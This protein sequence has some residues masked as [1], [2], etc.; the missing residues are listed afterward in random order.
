MKTTPTRALEVIANYTPMD[1]KVKELAMKTALRVHTWGY[2]TNTGRGHS[3]IRK[4]TGNVNIMNMYLMPKD[5]IITEYI[6]EKK[7]TT[8]IGS[9]EEWKTVKIHDNYDIVCKE[10]NIEGYSSL[11]KYAT[12]FQ[13]ETVAISNC[14]HEM[15]SLGIRRKNIAISTDSR[16]AILALDKAEIKSKTTKE[17]KTKLNTLAKMGKKISIIWVPGHND[18]Y[19]NERAD[20][21]ANLG[22]DSIPVGPEPIISLPETAYREEIRKWR[23]QE[24][25]RKWAET[26]E[27]T[28]AKELLGGET[29]VRKRSK[30]KIQMEKQ[31]ARDVVSILTGH[32]LLNAYLN[33]MGVSDTSTCRKCEKARETTKHILCECSRL[34]NERLKYLGNTS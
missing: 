24:K 32:A 17:Y 14:I 11:G 27:C 28:Q 16:A 21:L 1:I 5:R 3:Q 20:R 10:L 19:G 29:N 6:F 33:K 8:T 15:L 31:K 34:M 9:R 25:K 13:A 18:I 7:F 2:W 30:K 4:Q 22:S 23:E 26:G 12:V